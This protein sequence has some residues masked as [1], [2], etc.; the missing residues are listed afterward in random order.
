MLKNYR[1]CYR[2]ETYIEAK[3]EEEAR[4]YFEAS[5]KF[6]A[7]AEFVEVLTVEEEDPDED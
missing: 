4:A 6:T 2:M 7:G 5:M 3:S 1:I